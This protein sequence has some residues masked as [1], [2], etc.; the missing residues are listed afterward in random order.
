MLVLFP[1]EVDFYRRHGIEA[2]HVG[3][4]LVDEVP[5]LDH[6][7]DREPV[8][9]PHRIALL[10]GSRQ[11]E[12]RVLLPIL[13]QSAARIAERLPVRFSLIRAP[14]IAPE[15]LQELLPEGGPSIDIVADGRLAELAR[16]HLALCA[17]GTATLEVGL[18]GTPMIVVHRVAPVSYWMGRLLVRLPHASLVNLILQREAVPELLQRQAEP[19][20]IARA[21]ASL[22]GDADRIRAMRSALAGLRGRIGPPGASRRAAQAVVGRLANK[23]SGA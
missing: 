18:V 6:I 11:S 14:S 10:P 13:L 22:L 2:V 12:V 19:E 9:G 15:L 1:F 23:T 16:S 8:D 20:G 5:E 7:W 3:H 4:P 21:A 17:A